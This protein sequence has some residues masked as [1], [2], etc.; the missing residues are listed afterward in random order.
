M[1]V[2]LIG[3]EAVNKALEMPACIDLI[4]QVQIGISE[5]V[6]NNPQRSFIAL[7]EKHNFLGVMPGE[8]IEKGVFGAKLI[9]L[10]PGNPK[11]NRQPAIQGYV[12]LFDSGTGAPLAFVDAASITAI[13]TAAASAA[14]THA[15]ARDNA[16]VLSLLGYGVQAKGHLQAVLEVR[17]IHKVYV[18]G[19]TLT[20]ARALADQNSLLF[21]IEI[22]AVDQVEVAVRNADILC[23]VSNASQAI[24]QGSWLQEG[25]H[26]NLVG[27]HTP[28]TREADALTM[29][30]SRIFTEISDIALSESG[31]LLLAIASGDISSSDIIGEIGLVYNGA[32]NGRL[33][34]TDITLYKNLGNTAQDIICAEYVFRNYQAFRVSDT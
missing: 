19:P 22:Q 30:R 11:L 26:I 16:K 9:S 13:R 25:V 31:D 29:S 5:G 14:A 2:P 7:A 6:I 3:Q 1:N 4:R 28:D 12:V 32:I 33:N 8:L 21:D 10:Y 27:A 23:A 18:W 20:K 24:I 34:S 15:L 17:D